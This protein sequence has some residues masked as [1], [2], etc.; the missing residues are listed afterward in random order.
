[1][2][3]N[4]GAKLIPLVRAAV[5]R[6]LLSLTQG[7]LMSFLS[8]AGSVRQIGLLLCASLLGPSVLAGDIVGKVQLMEKGGK[9][10]TDLSDVVVYIDSARAKAKPTKVVVTMKSKAFTP[11]VLAIGTGTTVEFP[12]EDP[13]L[14]NV[15][16]ISAEGFDLGLYKR[17]KS[18]LRTFD[19]PG[20]YTLYCNIHPQ[21][22][23]LVVVRDNP[24][25]AQATKEGG[26]RIEA[27]PAGE[28]KVVAFHERS[29]EG[30]PVT[31]K[32]QATGEATL[33]LMLDAASYKR[34]PHKNK[35]GKEYGREAY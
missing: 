27:V 5:L 34:V 31:V 1:M 20:V 24:Y 18:G 29:G 15:F 19:K 32:V 21:M 8:R 22:S 26:F 4:D 12:N 28:Y 30:A 6:G 9:K 11:H 3:S 2:T 14:H 35:F 10:A 23:A 25:F 13:I 7:G 16:S 17:P 33:S